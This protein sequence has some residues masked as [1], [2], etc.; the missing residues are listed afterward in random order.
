VTGWWF[1]LDTPVSSTNKTDHH[2]ITEISLK[3][4]LS[5]IPHTSRGL[6]R[7]DRVTKFYA[8]I[9]DNTPLQLRKEGLLWYSNFY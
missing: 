4:E 5:T 7:H 8:F 2:D 3:V 9:L 6:I 1:S